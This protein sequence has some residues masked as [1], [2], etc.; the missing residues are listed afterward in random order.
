[1]KRLAGWLLAVLLVFS[2]SAALAQRVSC[3]VGGFS[4]TLPDRFAELPLNPG[5]DP[6]LCFYWQGSKLTVQAYA[7]YQGEVAGS[8]LF[9]VLTGYETDYGPVTVNGMDMLYA[10]TEEYG[11]VRISYTWMDRGNSV[12]LEFS[13]S[14]DDSSVQGTVNDIIHS[15]SFDAGH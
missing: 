7:S 5:L 1:M 15:I 9:Q 11:E 4:V 14:Q 3:P 6:D 8:D 12:T 13:Y 2:V 10:R